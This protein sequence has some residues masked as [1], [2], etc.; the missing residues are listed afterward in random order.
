EQ[1]A[2]LL[3]LAQARLGRRIT[4]VGRDKAVDKPPHGDEALAQIAELRRRVPGAD[5]IGSPE[6]PEQRRLV[7]TWDE[8]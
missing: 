6:T 1:N 5:R 3:E 7:L 8:A 2:A 4:R